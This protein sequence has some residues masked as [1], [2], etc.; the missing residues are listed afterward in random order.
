MNYKKA[1]ALMALVPFA[2][3]MASTYAAEEILNDSVINVSATTNVSASSAAVVSANFL[4]N[5]NVIVDQSSN[6]EMYKLGSEITRREMI[7]VAMNISGQTV[8]DSCTGE[9]S[10]LDSS[11]FECK[12]A[13]AALKAGFIA[14]NDMFRPDDNITEAESLKMIM[15]VKGIERDANADWRLGYSSK[16]QSEGLID[17]QI[18]LGAN[19]KRSW[20]FETAARSYTEFNLSAMMDDDKMMDDD[21]MMDNEDGVMVGGAMMVESKNIVQ[22]AMNAS[23]VTTLVAAVEAAGLVETLEGEGPFTVFAPTNAAF[24]KLPDGTVTTLLMAENKAQLADI[25][26]YHVVAGSYTSADITDGLELTTVNGEKLMFNVD[27]NGMITV[28]GEAMVETKDV[29]S[30]NGVTFVIDTVL[31]PAE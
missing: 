5:Q 30:S 26:T 10:D 20:I 8:T 23:N 19:A 24:E 29:M 12:Y 21:E 17:S 22:N 28:N 18:D 6:T 7:K 31:M 25:L 11:D 14:N 3:T 9:F 4:A 15:Q 16:A 13:E 2:G 1:V 27:A